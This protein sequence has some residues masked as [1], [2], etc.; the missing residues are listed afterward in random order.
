MGRGCV[1]VDSPAAS[2]TRVLRF[3]STRW[4]LLLRDYSLL[5]VCRKDENKEKDAKNCKKSKYSSI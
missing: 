2:D 4:Q 5:I 3:D 1:T